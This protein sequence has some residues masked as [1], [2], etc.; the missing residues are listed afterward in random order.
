MHV[1]PKKKII[2]NGHGGDELGLAT[3]IINGEDLGP[4]VR[5]AFQVGK[6]EILLYQL[7]NVAKKKELEIEELCKRHYED[8]IRAVDELRGVLVDADE[9]KNGLMKENFRLQEASTSLLMQL[10]ELLDS[11]ST[12]TNVTM[13]IE[14]SKFCLEVVQLCSK[15]NNDI[16]KDRLYPALKTLDLIERDYLLKIP[17]KCL[18]RVIENQIPVIKSHIEKKVINDF[19]DWLVVIRST[20][21][22]VGQQATRHTV[23]V[24]QREEDLRTRQREAEEK[25]QSGL[26]DCD[27]GLDMEHVDEDVGIKL[28][29]TPVYRAYHIHTCL[30]LQ[31]QFQS[32]Y[33]KNRLMQLNLDLQLTAAQS[34]LESHQTFF[35]QIAGFFIIEDRVLRTAGSLLSANQLGTMWD[36]TISKVSSILREQFS[37]IDSANNLLL[38]KDNVALLISTLKR[39]GYPVSSLLELL[40]TSRDKYHELLLKECRKQIDEVLARDTY[41]QMVMKKEYEYTMNVLAFNL[42]TSNI[43]PAFPYVAPFSAAVPDCCRVVRSFIEGSVSYSSYG[44]HVDFYDVVKKYLDKLLINVLNEALLRMISTCTSTVSQA[45][46][47]AANLIGLE[48]ACD[49]FL[50]QAAQLCGLPVRVAERPHASL[51]ARAVLKTSQ[52]AAYD[53]LLKLVNSKVDEFMCLAENINWTADE[54]QQNEYMNEVVIYLDTLLSTAQQILPM[55]ALYKVGSGA[56]KHISDTIVA[57]FLSDNVKRFNLNA[58]MSIDNDLKILE[59]FADERFESS[60]LCEINIEG[61]LRDCLIEV[62]QL[63]NLLLSSQPENFMNPVI[64]ERNYSSLD[65]KKVGIICEKFRDS[66]DRLFG[67]LSSRASKQDT[68][69][70]SMEVLRKSLKDLS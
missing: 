67:S 37:H 43:M 66:P 1:K 49:L 40:G 56:L 26:G 50:K 63:V 70:K 18:S 38:I 54:V 31:D 4:I 35:T 60:G 17:V 39:Y 9:L 36:T 48:H 58:V 57:A 2:E 8:F 47:I 27:Y 61:S 23:L 51:S 45:M 44:G 19:N 33:Y 55:E 21:K 28:D 46:Q 24:R 14:M 22:E 10:E 42:Q 29:L 3:A 59:S 64:R 62:R 25:S 11:H 69:K 34:F 68:R 32:Y 6:P 5:H 13:A 52:D 53:A 41:E 12:K 65:H 30:G 20:A 7:K 15:C 16:L